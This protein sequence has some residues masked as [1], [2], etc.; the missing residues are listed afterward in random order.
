MASSSEKRRQAKRAARARRS[1]KPAS[2]TYVERGGKTVVERSTPQIDAAK[3]ASMKLW[4]R[5][6][7]GFDY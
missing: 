4:T 2:T 1:S 7:S 3:K 6:N 5:L